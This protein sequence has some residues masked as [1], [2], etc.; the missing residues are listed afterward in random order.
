MYPNS[1]HS[2]TCAMNASTSDPRVTQPKS[3]TATPLF[4]QQ[5]NWLTNNPTLADG[6]YTF[7][8]TAQLLYSN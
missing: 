3:A 8:Q 6:N 2:P 1:P 7:W 4:I 5:N